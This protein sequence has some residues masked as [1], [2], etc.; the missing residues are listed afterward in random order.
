MRAVNEIWT[1][2]GFGVETNEEGLT[3]LV[4]VHPPGP[5]GQLVVRIPFDDEGKAKLI[6][7]LTGTSLVVATANDMPRLH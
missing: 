6:Q 2:V 3:V 5:E 1:G 7:Q 4:I